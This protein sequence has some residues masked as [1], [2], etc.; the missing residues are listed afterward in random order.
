MNRNA[1]FLSLRVVAIGA[2]SFE[3]RKQLFF[4]CLLPLSLLKEGF[5]ALSR[6]ELCRTELI[7]C[8]WILYGLIRSRLIRR[9]GIHHRGCRWI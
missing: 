2:V 3:E 5:V 4:Q 8:G 1:A 7:G 9:S 6:S